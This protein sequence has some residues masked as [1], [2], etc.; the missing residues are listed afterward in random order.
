TQNL[1]V[2]PTSFNEM[3]RLISPQQVNV[4]YSD[5]IVSYIHQQ[6]PYQASSYMNFNLGKRLSN[7]KAVEGEEINLGD[8]LKLIDNVGIKSGDKLDC[9]DSHDEEFKK[10]MPDKMEITTNN[11]VESTTTIFEVMKSEMENEKNQENSTTIR[12][13]EI[14][15]EEKIA[16]PTHLDPPLELPVDDELKSKK[17]PPCAA[18]KALVESFKKGIEKTKRGKFEGGDTAWEEDNQKSY[19]KSEVRLTEIQEGLCKDLTSGE[20]QCHDL[21]E[22]L[23]S[24]IEEWWFKHQDKYPDIYVYICIKYAKRCCPKDHYGV[25]CKQ[26]AGFPNKVC[27]N[28]GRCKGS[29]TRKGNGQCQC[30]TGYAG[31]TCLDCAVGYYEAYR[32]E[33]KLLCS[34]CHA[35]CADGCKSGGADNCQGNCKEGWKKN[36]DNKEG[37]VDINECLDNEICPGNQFCVNTEGNYSCLNC[38]SACNGCNGDGPD[39]CIKCADDHEKKDNVCINPEAIGRKE[40]EN[41]MRYATYLGLCIATCIILQR[42]VY[43]ASVIGLIVGIYISLSEYF[44]ANTDLQDGVPEFDFLPPFM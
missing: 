3:S 23:E 33:N 26:C 42:N 38:D 20:I 43:A 7:M 15:T 5:P 2:P 41:Y 16:E 28:N 25:D 31:E 11:I 29:G 24:G 14:N 39:M 22:E 37:C 1:F 6:P 9:N 10:E 36:D 44:I 32:D 35:S 17:L 34:S 13:I 30:D 21:A 40:R 18:C 8:D 19:A 12:D 4:G 27:N